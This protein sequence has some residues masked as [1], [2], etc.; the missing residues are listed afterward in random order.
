KTSSSEDIF[1]HIHAAAQKGESLFVKEQGGYELETHYKYMASI[2]GFRDIME[3]ML[4]AGFSVPTFQI[5]HC[6]FFSQGYLMFIT[7]EPVPQMHEI[8]KRFAK[9]FEQ[10]YT[11]FLD[12]QRA[13]AQAR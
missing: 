5:I 9:V 12:L 2:P 8:F 6:A 13:E 3:R 10:T 4:K 1:L 7:Y 11:R